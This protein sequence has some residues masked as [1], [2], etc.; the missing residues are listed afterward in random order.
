MVYVFFIVV[1]A[2]WRFLWMCTLEE[3]VIL[4]FAR[5]ILFI[6]SLHDVIH[7]IQTNQVM[8]EEISSQPFNVE[9]IGLTA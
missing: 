2:Y 1:N 9:G 5:N 4:P 6:P 3:N 8:T 7:N